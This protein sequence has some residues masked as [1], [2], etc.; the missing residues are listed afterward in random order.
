MK[1][2]N[3]KFITAMSAM[4]IA[5]MVLVFGMTIGCEQ[6]ADEEQAP[7][8]GLTLKGTAAG[9]VYVVRV[10]TPLEDGT[11]TFD[12]WTEATADEKLAAKGEATAEGEEVL[13]SL[14]APEESP[15]TDAFAQ[16]GSFLVVVTAGE[17]TRYADAPFLNG[18][19]DLDLAN[20]EDAP[21]YPDYS[22]SLSQTETLEFPS[23]NEGYAAQK[24]TTITVT[25]TGS[26]ATGIL[27]LNVSKAVP[28]GGFTLNKTAIDSITK[29]DGTA[30]FTVGPKTGLSSGVYTATVTVSG[31]SDDLTRSIDVSFTVKPEGENP[32]DGP[33]EEE[34]SEED[35]SKEDPAEEDTSEEDTSEEDTSEE[36]TSEE[37][38]SEEDTSGED[39]SE[40][41]T[42]E[43]DTSE[44][45]PV[46]SIALDLDGLDG[47]GVYTNGVYT[48]PHKYFGIGE[49]EVKTVR[50]RNTGN[51]PT[52]EL[53]V[54]LGGPSN[55]PDAFVLSM[56]KIA[57]IASHGATTFTVTPKEVAGT[58]SATVTVGAAADN[59]AA[60]D[61]QSFGVTFAVTTLYHTVTFISNGG[62]DVPPQS[63]EYGKS[64]AS[65]AAPS[66]ANL[67][68]KNWYPNL[69]A[70]ALPFNFSTT[71]ITENITLYAKWYAIV[72]FDPDGGSSV[73]TRNV[74]EDDAIVRPDDPTKEDYNFNAWYTAADYTE[75]WNFTA[76][77]N[78]DMTLYAGWVP[79]PS[80]TFSQIIEWLPGTANSASASYTMRSGNETYTTA[81]SLTTANCS[82][83]V[84]IDGGGRVIT[85]GTNGISVGSGVT[86][87]LRN[88]TFTTLPF[89][90][91][92]GG[93]L[94][95]ETG[96]VIQENSVTGVTVN[97]G[98]LEMKTGALITKNNSASVSGGGVRMDGGTFTMS[99]G[100]ISDNRTTA[101]GGGV[102]LDGENTVF[103]LSGSGEISGNTAGGYGGGV[104]IAFGEGIQVLNQIFDM[105]GGIIKDN[106]AGHYGGGLC[107]GDVTSVFN[108]T[109]GEITGNTI[110]YGGSGGGVY[111]NFTTVTG[112]PS[113]GTKVEGKGSVYGNLKGDW[114]N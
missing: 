84:V 11:D 3:R 95:L 7:Q 105:S 92:A 49:Q 57:G 97:G 24:A 13:V 33:S 59:S 68:F 106:V 30:E 46:Y 47:N 51:R 20:M 36:D 32:S 50:I 99:G 9:A 55:N 29:K 10:Y 100:E 64:A 62:S 28:S 37:D 89:T 45:A 93:K 70:D 54:S 21:E 87:T 73:T 104:R 101:D 113:I 81:V 58:F 80:T 103:T 78:R 40:E 61:P 52:G 25:N 8:V 22:I 26:K 35:A 60:I 27:T 85:G 74:D 79:S 75:E 83:T 108:M 2:L 114:Q 18:S 16:T 86:L 77:V 41:D 67:H 65:P 102:L 112:D 94:V 107:G 6:D 109:G 71:P 72:A 56:A 110:T 4:L 31:G 82:A 111:I 39:T 63:I 12:A 66:K 34:P 42:S 14:S 53:A 23:V 48:F 91:A 90:V 15:G 43:E 17:T 44:T 96:A 76:P 88:I 98:A 69:T 5:L 19:A 1:R 38:T